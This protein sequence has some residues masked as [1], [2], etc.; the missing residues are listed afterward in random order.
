MQ[1]SFSQVVLKNLLSIKPMLLCSDHVPSRVVGAQ[2]IS[3][4]KKDGDPRAGGVAQLLEY[5]PSM[6]EAL[7]SSLSMT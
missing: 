1:K 3:V 7:G 6:Q 2:D 4:H 5:F